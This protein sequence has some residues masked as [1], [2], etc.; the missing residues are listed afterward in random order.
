MVF[1][2][3]EDKGENGRVAGT[4]NHLSDVRSGL[5]TAQGNGKSPENMATSYEGLITNGATDRRV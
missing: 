5:H 1:L 4:A 2:G 3:P